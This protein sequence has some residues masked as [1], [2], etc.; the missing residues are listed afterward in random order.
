MDS[1]ARRT[2]PRECTTSTEWPSSSS[3]SE[4]LIDENASA[5]RAGRAI[6]HQNCCIDVRIGF[7]ITRGCHED[8]VSGNCS[9]AELWP[10]ARP[11]SAERRVWASQSGL[12]LFRLSTGGNTARGRVFVN[13]FPSPRAWGCRCPSMP[14]SAAFRADSSSLPSATVKPSLFQFLI[15][16]NPDQGPDQVYP[17][18]PWKHSYSTDEKS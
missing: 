7:A 18:P 11:G 15:G 17:P 3:T 5:T 2:A 1:A 6:A 14:L 4:R 16:S 12:M 13:I 8:D 10:R 9:T